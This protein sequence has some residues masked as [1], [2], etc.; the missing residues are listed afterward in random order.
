MTHGHGQQC[1]DGL[2]EQ[3]V[4]WGGQ[5]RSKSRDWDNCSRINKNKRKAGVE[6][7]IINLYF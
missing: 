4:G 3:G 1:G 7:E 2:W 5:R 6:V